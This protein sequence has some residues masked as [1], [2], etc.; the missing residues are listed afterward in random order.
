MSQRIVV[1]ARDVWDYAQK[2]K[3]R[4]RTSMHEIASNS[5]FGIVI[6]I[7]I[8]EG[9]DRPE[10][11]V[12]ADGDEVYFEGVISAED[13]RETVD[14]IYDKY[15][16]S[17]VISILSGDS[18]DEAEDDYSQFALEDQIAAREAELDDA[19]YMF[20]GTVC[21]DESCASLDEEMIEDVKE[22]FLEYLARKWD[23]L[24]R[25]PMFLEDEDG[26]DFFEE[27]PYEYMAFDDEDNPI[28]K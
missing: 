12:S 9:K 20:L 22:H 5:D 13:C 23:L 1:E 19:L 26:E 4:L 18:D 24:I 25:R 11:V 16:T 2:Y 15:L 8:A 3:E 14:R 10:I 7:T 28:Y 6:Y 21:D 27:Y 17:T